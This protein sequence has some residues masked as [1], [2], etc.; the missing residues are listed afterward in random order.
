MHRID[1]AAFAGTIRFMTSTSVDPSDIADTLT[2]MGVTYDPACGMPHLGG[3][4]SGKVL[5]AY[6]F[7]RAASVGVTA[8]VVSRL[9]L[10]GRECPVV[11]SPE[12]VRYPHSE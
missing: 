8:E 5:Q 12:L 6:W 3:C 1:D 9:P 2:A 7:M 4:G 10:Y 11:V